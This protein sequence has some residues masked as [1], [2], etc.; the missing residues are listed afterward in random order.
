MMLSDVCLSVAYI[1]PKSRTERP[2]KTK[3][4]TEVAHVTRDSDTT[5]KVKRSRSSGR[6]THRCVG[7]SGSCS[8]GCGNVLAVRN[9]CYVAVCSAALQ[10]P[11]GRGAGAY[12]GGRPPTACLTKN[13]RL[14]ERKQIPPSWPPKTI[15]ISW[16]HIHIV[17]IIIKCKIY[18][19]DQ[20]HN[21]TTKGDASWTYKLSFHATGSSDVCSVL[22][23]NNARINDQLPGNLGKLVPEN[24]MILDYAALRYGD[25]G[26]DSNQNSKT[27]NAPVKSP[28]S[29]SGGT[30]EEH[31]RFLDAS[32]GR[33]IR[34][35]PQCRVKSKVEQFE[36][37]LDC[38]KPGL[39]RASSL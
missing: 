8:G 36:I 25:G 32:P 7:A 39:T 13:G 28:S 14:P 10:R 18:N 5:F 30:L 24:Q 29:S 16:F 4:D 12:R 19:F 22:N 21:C 9:C 23:N 1:G 11:Q 26:G 15:S 33:T 35:S 38:S 27:C 31:S 34:C 17:T 2:R 37:A 20:E 3:I 6:F